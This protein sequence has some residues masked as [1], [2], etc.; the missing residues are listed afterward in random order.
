MSEAVPDDGGAGTLTSAQ[1]APVAWI[2]SADYEHRATCF[3]V[4]DHW[5]AT[6]GHVFPSSLDAAGFVVVFNYV[7]GGDPGSRDAYALHPDSG[8]VK[9]EYDEVVDFAFVRLLPRPNAAPP[10]VR[11]GKVD[12]SQPATALIGASVINVQHPVQRN[13]KSFSS[14][15]VTGLDGPWI[16]HDADADE[17]ASGAPL[18]DA[19]GRWVGIHKGA[20]GG[21]WRASS[22]PEVAARVKQRPNLPPDLAQ[23]FGA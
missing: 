2:F 20:T 10:S 4:A 21:S 1:C 19:N 15:T 14:G 9:A 3:L 23:A 7:A 16:I 22:A 5:I 18:F 13:V 8:F 6:A 11:W 17:G 12:I